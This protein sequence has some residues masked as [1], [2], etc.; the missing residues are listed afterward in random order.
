[1]LRK[2]CD[3]NC[4]S[5]AKGAR[6]CGSSSL[7]HEKHLASQLPS[8]NPTVWTS[9]P[10]LAFWNRFGS[11]LVATWRSGFARMFTGSRSKTSK[12]WINFVSRHDLVG[13]RYNSIP[14]T[15]GRNPGTNCI[16][17]L[18]LVRTSML[19]GACPSFI[20]KR[21]RHCYTYASCSRSKQAAN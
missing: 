5:R 3:S 19:P 14:H 8:S 15:H 7:R 17:S 4:C 1:M 16:L 2:Y 10:R 13:Y 18:G 9:A 21:L 12:T 6:H 11:L 20:A